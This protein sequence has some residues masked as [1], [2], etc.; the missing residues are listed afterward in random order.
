MNT[1]KNPRY[2]L[3]IYGGMSLINNHS[4]S[5]NKLSCPLLAK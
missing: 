3:P 2:F 4:E 5:I 1:K